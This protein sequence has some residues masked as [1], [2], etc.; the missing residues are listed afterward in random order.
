M[1]L[2]DRES[3]KLGEKILSLSSAD[4][5]R[6][7]LSGGRS[8]NTR[9]ALNSITTSGE[10]D[11]LS[12]EVTSYFGKRHATASTT[13]IDE[14]SLKRTVQSAET[15]AQF[16]PE[17]PEYV[18]EL[19]PQEYLDIDTYFATTARTT[20]RLRMR[21]AESAINSSVREKLVSAG[22]FDHENSFS[23]VMN[24]H[25]LHA[26]AKSTFASFSV[27]V[28]TPD[29]T[30]SGWAS[31]GSRN[32]RDVDHPTVSG[33]AIQKAASSR[34]PKILEPGN[35]PVILEPQAVADFIQ[36]AGWSMNARYADEG[37]SFFSRPGGGNKIGEKVAGENITVVS[38]PTHPE[39]LGRPFW[40]DGLPARKLVWIRNGVLGQLF[41][42]RYWAQKQKKEPTGFPSNI[43]FEGENRTLEDLIQETDRAVLVT[44]FWYIRFVDPQTI[45]LT[46]L[47]R[48]GTFW[49]ED[50]EVRHAI[51]NFRFNE[52][53]MAVLNRVTGMTRP[54]R[55]GGMLVPAIRASEFTFS[56]LSEAV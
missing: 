35:Y 54:E 33:K 36:F 52:S 39:L 13:E 18:P 4:E 37:R 38:D 28:R 31:E 46:G 44:R 10:E 32:V 3:R 7:N 22:Y 14:V 41:Y 25:G 30:G 53:P 24:N 40:S 49:I 29:G 56:S 11:T 27:T 6:V 1:I 8:G 43:V 42:D 19:G 48:D 26:Y 55:A 16:S 34:D 5:V 23:S 20:P 21:S 47:T 45:L 50:G 9:F 51:K 15:A 2:S 12:V 17:D